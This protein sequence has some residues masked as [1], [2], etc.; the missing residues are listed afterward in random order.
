ML[1]TCTLLLSLILLQGDRWEHTVY[2]EDI[3]PVEK[4]N[5]KIELLA[6]NGV[7]P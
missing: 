1:S 5:G 7:A 4:S 2:V 3:L 6:G